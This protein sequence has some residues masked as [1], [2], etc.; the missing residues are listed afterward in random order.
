MNL[1]RMR[2]KAKWLAAGAGFAVSTYAMYA[3]TTYARYGKVPRARPGEE[4]D[5]LDRFIPVYDV[6]ERH[7]VR[8]EASAAVTL[9]VAKATELTQLPGVHAIFRAREW[10]L[11]SKPTERTSPRGLVDETRSLGWVVLAEAPDREIVMGAVTRP[12]EPNVTFRS[13]APESF[14]AFDEPDYVKI[15]WTLRADPVGNEASIFRTETRAYAT[16]LQARRKF[17]RYWSLLSPGIILIRWLSLRPVKT[18]A[19]RRARTS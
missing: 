14:A 6:V 17:R 10:L 9:S 5:L 11:G 15:A 13:I 16:D 4:D 18:E 1:P 7:H 19:E 2:S 12:W 8:V 3:G